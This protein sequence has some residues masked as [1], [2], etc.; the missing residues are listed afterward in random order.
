MHNNSKE[1]LEQVT[2]DH[3]Y[4]S[5]A[6]FNLLQQMDTL[7]PNYAQQASK[8]ALYFNNNY[9]LHFQLEQKKQEKEIVPQPAS[10]MAIENNTDNNDDEIIQ[11]TEAAIPEPEYEDNTDNEA[12]ME[13]E[14]EPMKLSLKLPEE[15]S[16]GNDLLFEPMHLV[17]YFASQGIK[18]SEEV[19]PTD[20][21]G[22]QMKSFTE[23]L[24]TMKKVHPPGAV[25]QNT[26]V[27]LNPDLVEKAIQTLA[28][29]SNSEDEI[30]TES[31]ADV[32]GRQGKLAKA[33]EL[34]QKLSLLNPSKSAYFAAKIENL[35]GS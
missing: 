17:D 14:I 20:K 33:V 24:K 6:Q 26:A 22:K 31:M 35:K 28:E 30:L 12:Q 32:L 15:H 16:K 5:V 29:K 9:W 11:K 23:W 13:H 2:A 1:F 3:P 19:Q 7:A 18:L 10:E 34:Y 4:F 8:T 27:T 25:P 21:L